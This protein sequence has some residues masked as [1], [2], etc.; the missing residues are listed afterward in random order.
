MQQD[1]LDQVDTARANNYVVELTE[2]EWE[3]YRNYAQSTYDDFD[4]TDWGETTIAGYKTGWDTVVA[5][6]GCF[7]QNKIPHFCKTFSPG[8]GG[9]YYVN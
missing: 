4:R 8:T 6:V 9:E 7:L 5:S 1:T 3:W 2:A